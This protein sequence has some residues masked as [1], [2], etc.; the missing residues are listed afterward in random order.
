MNVA[1]SQGYA[2]PGCRM[3]WNPAAEVY[4]PGGPQNT[5]QLEQDVSWSKGRHSMRFGGQWTYIQMTIAYGAY[6]QAVEYL[7]PNRR[8]SWLPPSAIV[9]RPPLSAMTG[10]GAPM[11]PARSLPTIPIR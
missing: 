8:S 1:T 3:K 9:F 10:S 7:R 5:V 11:C 4:P 6:A 2:G